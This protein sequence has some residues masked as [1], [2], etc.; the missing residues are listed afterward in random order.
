MRIIGHRGCTLAP[1]NTLEA[2]QVAVEAGASMI[3]TDLR[4]TQDSE[5]VL[6]HDETLERLTGT[7]G[8]I[9]D[10]TLRELKDLRI[11]GKGMIPTLEELIEQAMSLGFDIN[12]EIKE[13][14]LED[15]ILRILKSKDFNR[16]III[17]SLFPDILEIFAVQM[18]EFEMNIQIAAL[19]AWPMTVDEVQEAVEGRVVHG[20]HP[21]FDQVDI[22]FVDDL[23]SIGY[24]VNLWTPNTEDE[25]KKSIELNP[26]GII[27]DR[28]DILSELLS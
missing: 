26:S 20:F 3:E 10:F 9:S 27:T 13:P 7:S 17:T 16:P 21:R 28:P 22:R 12:L 15:D 19:M 25:L 4:V 14:E 2:F 11:N 6:F 1:E 23:R 18:E 8:L 5:I 24:F